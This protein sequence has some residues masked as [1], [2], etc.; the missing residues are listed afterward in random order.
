MCSY[1][2]DT[3]QH[4]S[5]ND[6]G[7]NKCK[8]FNILTIKEIKIMNLRIGKEQCMERDGGQKRKWGKHRNYYLV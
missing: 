7:T 8:I 2:V 3:T 6:K 5:N 4:Q 1:V